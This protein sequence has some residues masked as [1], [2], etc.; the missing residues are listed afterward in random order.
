MTRKYA[1]RSVLCTWLNCR[2]LAYTSG[3]VTPQEAVH[4]VYYVDRKEMQH[5]SEQ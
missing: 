1:L 2:G 5:G 3:L 4:W